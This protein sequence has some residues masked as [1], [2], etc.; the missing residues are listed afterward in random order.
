MCQKSDMVYG[1]V[2]AGKK[3]HKKEEKSE[4]PS[5]KEMMIEPRSKDE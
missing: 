4:K 2:G 1:E 5:P 3:R